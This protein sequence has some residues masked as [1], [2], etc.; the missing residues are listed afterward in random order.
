MSTDVKVPLIFDADEMAAWFKTPDVDW[1][2]EAVKTALGRVGRNPAT[3]SETLPDRR[4][5]LG[6]GPPHAA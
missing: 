2:V 4:P 6:P 3:G 5:A 1:T